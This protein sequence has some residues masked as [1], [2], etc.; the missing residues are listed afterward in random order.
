MKMMTRFLLWGLLLLA[1]AAEGQTNFYH[2]L[3][4]YPIFTS[5]TPGWVPLS[6]GGTTNFL[7]ADGTWA[8]PAGGGG[9]GT[10]GGSTTQVQ[11]NNAGAF[12]GTS[13]FTYT[14]ATSSLAVTGGATVG[15]LSVTGNATTG[16]TVTMP[17]AF[18]FSQAPATSQ[19][20][21]V[22]NN[23]WTFGGLTTHSSGATFGVAG[24]TGAISILSSN[25]S[26]G[27]TLNIGMGGTPGFRFLNSAANAWVPIGSLSS[28]IASTG[29]FGFGSTTNPET[30]DGAFSRLGAASV[31]LGNG[32][33]GNTSGA[34]SLGSLNIVSGG[35][36]VIALANTGGNN[37]SGSYKATFGGSSASNLG[38]IMT[39]EGS[40][41]A[42]LYLG[43]VIPGTSNY[44][45]GAS[46]TVTYITG[47]TSIN[48]YVN[49]VALLQLIGNQ[50]NLLWGLSTPAGGTTGAGL[51]FGTTTNFGIFFGSGAPTL[52]AAQGSLYLRSDG[53]GSTTRAYINSSSGSGTTWTSL[54]TAG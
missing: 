4:Q 50:A 32:T 33:A 24:T 16:A 5:T 27:N 31:A 22:T 25:L 44:V 39:P 21:T 6:G 35:A 10:P 11:F 28:W 3:D 53:S 46:S 47:P 52:S 36:N 18:G 45:L 12:G 41:I 7:R 20:A 34:L 40:G 1:G 23:L 15:T 19:G 51:T 43:S 26:A 48:N 37:V 9:G 14:Q 30:Q 29:T 8:V 17:A 54:T 38:W 13:G 49:G 2:I 42:G